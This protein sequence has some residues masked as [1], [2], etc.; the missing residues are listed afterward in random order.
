MSTAKDKVVIT[1]ESASPG[2]QDM[3]DGQSLGNSAEPPEDPKPGDVV[4]DKPVELKGDDSR[5]D[6]YNKFREQRVEDEDISGL[7]EEQQKHVERMRLEASG[8][9]EDP[10]PNHGQPDD[11]EERVD[12]ADPANERPGQVDE[13]KPKQEKPAETAPEGVD[14]DSDLVTITVYGINEQ[15]PR[16]E[17]DAVGG[18]QKFQKMRAAEVRMERAA[19]YEASLRKYEDS[20][21]QRNAELDEREAT[22]AAREKALGTGLPDGVQ[23]NTAESTGSLDEQARAVVHS[24]YA[25]DEEDAVK[26]MTDLLASRD[27]NSAM[28]EEQVE[29]AVR[30]VLAETSTAAPGT[31]MGE[32]EEARANQVF[33]NEFSHLNTHSGRTAILAMTE[34]L[35]KDPV[36]YGRPLDELTREAGRRVTEDF[37][38]TYQ[39]KPPTPAPQAENSAPAD[40]A[41]R[42]QRKSRQV[43]VP[44][45]PAAGQHARHQPEPEPNTAPMANNQAYIQT[46]RKNRGLYTD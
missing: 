8:E 2:G 3:M 21:Q 43:V 19:T 24:I 36:M 1:D 13:V 37:G 18:V 6:I 4:K 22:L 34:E 5:D 39:A 45:T 7:T 17:I 12:M 10:L 35:R 32:S 16:S 46:M 26:K 44:G 40:L 30:R 27:R 20:V 29:G 9:G 31:P 14:T 33:A 41:E 42:H 25:G 38:M 11:I 28:T 23:P 15:I